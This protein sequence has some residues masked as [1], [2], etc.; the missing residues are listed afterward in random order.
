MISFMFKLLK[1]QYKYLL[2]KGMGGPQSQFGHYREVKNLL[3][4]KQTESFLSC[5]AN[6]III[7]TTYANPASQY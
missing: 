3:P 7:N 2:N 1:P 5:P 4:L 6:R